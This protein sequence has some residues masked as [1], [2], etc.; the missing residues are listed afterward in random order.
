MNRSRFSEKQIIAI[1]EEQEARHGN[2]GGVPTPRDQ[3]GDLPSGSRNSEVWECRR[4]GGCAAS[5]RRAHG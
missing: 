1:L 3:H 4:R 2:G 5:R